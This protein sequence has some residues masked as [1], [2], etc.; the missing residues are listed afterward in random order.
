[1]R[2]SDLEI[3]RTLKSEGKQSLKLLKFMTPFANELL[4]DAIQDEYDLSKARSEAITVEVLGS[5]SETDRVIDW[6]DSSFKQVLKLMDKSTQS[7][8]IENIHAYLK[9]FQHEGVPISG[10]L[11]LAKGLCEGKG[12]SAIKDFDKEFHAQNLPEVIESEVVMRIG[13]QDFQH[14]EDYEIYKICKTTSLFNIYYVEVPTNSIAYILLTYLYSALSL[15]WGTDTESGAQRSLSLGKNINIT[16]ILPNSISL[17]DLSKPQLKHASKFI[18]GLS[19]SDILFESKFYVREDGFAETLDFDGPLWLFQVPSSFEINFGGVN[20][21]RFTDLGSELVTILP[22]DVRSRVPDYRLAPTVTGR[23]SD[24]R[25]VTRKDNLAHAIAYAWD[26]DYC[27]QLVEEVQSE[28]E[29]VA[30]AAYHRIRDAVSY[31]GES[32]FF[33]YTKYALHNFRVAD[34]S[35]ESLYLLSDIIDTVPFSTYPLSGDFSNVHMLISLEPK[36]IGPFD[37]S[38]PVVIFSLACTL[39][40]K[41]RDPKARDQIENLHTTYVNLTKSDVLTASLL[42]TLHADTKGLDM[43]FSKSSDFLLVD[44]NRPNAFEEFKLVFG[45]AYALT[46]KWVASQVSDSELPR[47]TTR[48]FTF[49]DSEEVDAEFFKSPPKDVVFIEPFV[50]YIP[51]EFRPLIAFSVEGVIY[52]CAD[53]NFMLKHLNS[54][55]SILLSNYEICDKRSEENPTSERR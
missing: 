27:C 34:M 30:S 48:D 33:V 1:M 28:Q 47:L 11:K 31:F 15:G 36:M 53:P 52:V 24:Y 6:V 39:G 13:A 14:N 37:A 51:S 46:L 38:N 5:K 22:N 25:I 21:S 16:Y 41:L 4:D 18:A 2:K 8:L 44:V 54:D 29:D 26:L 49:L 20:L 35:V 12:K 9:V 17:S 32:G 43:D 7:L 10:A 23:R 42:F 55:G 3:V 40:S 19:L 50:P 45:E